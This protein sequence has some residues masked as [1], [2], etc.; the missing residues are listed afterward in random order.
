MRQS[1]GIAGRVSPGTGADYCIR[2]NPNGRP[3]GVRE[4]CRVTET[5]HGHLPWAESDRGI[6]GGSADSSMLVGGGE[7]VSD[8]G[9]DRE[10]HGPPW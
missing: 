5:S 7:G 3:S 1:T 4:R 2:A 10:L 8:G 9:H 6:A